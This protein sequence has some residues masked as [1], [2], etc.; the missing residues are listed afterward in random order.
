MKYFYSVLLVVIGAAGMCSS[1]LFTSLIHRNQEK[2][3]DIE[4][5]DDAEIEVKQ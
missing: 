5:A 3:S 4:I 1:L 2:I